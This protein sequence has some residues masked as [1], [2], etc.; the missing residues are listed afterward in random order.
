[1]KTTRRF[2]AI[3]LITL[4]MAGM[5]TATGLSMTPLVYV[6]EASRYLVNRSTPEDTVKSYYE[7]LENKSFASAYQLLTT[8]AQN[9]TSAKDLEKSLAQ[10]RKSTIRTVLPTKPL[11]NYAAVIYV[12]SINLKGST[13]ASLVLGMDFVSREGFRGAWS[14]VGEFAEIPVKK[15]IELLANLLELNKVA[16]PGHPGLEGFSGQEKQGILSQLLALTTSARNAI[17]RA[18]NPIGSG[19]EIK[20]IDFG[21]QFINSFAPNSSRIFNW[22]EPK[23]AYTVPNHPSIE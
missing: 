15:R 8:Q 21:R 2:V 23:P 16:E 9:A 20:P 18:N 14:L 7:L 3:A 11:Q 22:R 4:I 17:E 19:F 13:Q 10:M 1:M 5:M 12:R 6:D